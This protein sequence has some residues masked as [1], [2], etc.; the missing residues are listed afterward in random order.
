MSQKI[1]PAMK[2]WCIELK[3]GA[4]ITRSRSGWDW[5]GPRGFTY[6]MGGKLERAGLI[7]VG[8]DRVATLTDAGRSLCA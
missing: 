8:Q 1:T 4:R 5:F 7:E 6:V 2:K 3:Y